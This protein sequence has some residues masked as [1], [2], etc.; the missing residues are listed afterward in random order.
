MWLDFLDNYGGRIKADGLDNF[1]DL[2]MDPITA[3]ICKK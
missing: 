2:M 1:Y 3:E